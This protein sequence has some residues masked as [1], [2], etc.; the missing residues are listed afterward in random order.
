MLFRNGPDYVRVSLH[1]TKYFARREIA[2][3]LFDVLS[4]YGGIYLPETWDLEE[5][6]HRRFDAHSLEDVIDAWT[7]PLKVQYVFFNRKRPA[8]MSM[9]VQIERFQRA[10]FNGFYASIRD[11]HFQGAEEGDELLRFV[12]DLCP[13][14]RPD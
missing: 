3:Q 6:T 9:Y 1:S 10:K 2:E 13:S 4:R 14:L 7:A 12:L 5:E 11:N 8:E